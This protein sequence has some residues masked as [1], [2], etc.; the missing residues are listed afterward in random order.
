MSLEVKVENGVTILRPKGEMIGGKE[1]DELQSKIKELSDAGN[2]ELII[3]LGKVTYMTSIGIGVLIS[4]H[5]NYVKRGAQV[6]LCG[7][8]ENIHQVFVMTRLVLVF[9][10]DT[11]RTEEEALASLTA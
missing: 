2:R 7:V 1:T 4:A 5:V 11:M 3:N 6:R 10:D 9:G 8:G